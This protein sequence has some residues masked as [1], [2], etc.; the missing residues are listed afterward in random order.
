[1]QNQSPAVKLIILLTY[2]IQTKF[3]LINFGKLLN[4][5]VGSNSYFPGEGY[6]SVWL[7]PLK[8]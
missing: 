8:S 3:P 4:I 2:Q 5:Q 1:M 7:I 6:L